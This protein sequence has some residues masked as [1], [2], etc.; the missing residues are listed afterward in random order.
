[1]LILGSYIFQVLSDLDYLCRKLK[2]FKKDEFLID[3]EK[4]LKKNEY[5]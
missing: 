5:L 2:Q 4:C 1:M 3:L